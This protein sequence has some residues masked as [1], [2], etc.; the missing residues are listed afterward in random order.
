MG[1]KIITIVAGEEA[2]K[3]LATFT[4]IED[5][6]RAVRQYKDKF[7]DQLTKST[8]AV[9]DLIKRYS[10]K[11]IGCSFLAKGSIADMLKISRKTVQRA[12]STLESLGVIKQ[13]ETK[14][15]TDKRQSTNA[16]Q[17]LPI[18]NNVQPEI[19]EDC[20]PNKTTPNLKQKPIKE[21]RKQSVPTE[22]FA[23]EFVKQASYFFS[24]PECQEL[25]K[26]RIIHGRINKLSS[27][28]LIEASVEALKITVQKFKQ[29]KAKNVKGYFNGCLQKLA[30]KY[31]VNNL[32]LNFF[33]N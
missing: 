3:N 24:E 13:L 2:Y 6:N 25:N 9:L 20:P 7:E 10:C 14:R 18:E 33:E 16:I 32:F 11:Y 19:Q 30:K 4:D 12:C 5:L 27:E 31:R 8:L 21:I 22:H 28:T 26:I 17:I 29:K 1:K 23:N 15:K